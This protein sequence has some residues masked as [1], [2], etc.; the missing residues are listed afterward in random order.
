MAPAKKKNRNADSRTDTI[1]LTTFGSGCSCNCEEAL[2]N[3]SKELV[4][5]QGKMSRV[6]ELTKSSKV[7]LGLRELMGEAFKCKICRDMIQ[8]PVIVTKCCKAMLG[9][10]EC[11]KS[12]YASDP[13]AKNC[14]G[15][16]TER[17]YGESM[18]LHGLDELLTAVKAIEQD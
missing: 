5:L 10:D 11:I 8:P 3:M 17:G 14:P 18:R 15:C 16:N 12:W 13:L 2:E 9:C 4:E 7:P 6:F 1:D